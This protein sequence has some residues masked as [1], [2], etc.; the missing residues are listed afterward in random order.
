MSEQARFVVVAFDTPEQAADA[1]AAAGQVKPIDAAV[2]V[3]EPNGRLD[4]HQ[5][6]QTSPGEGAIAGGTVGLL[7]GLLF[8]SPVVGALA[9]IAAGIG[10]GFRDTGIED[11]RIRAF[12]DELAPGKAILCVLLEEEKL[13]SLRERLEPYGGETIVA[14]ATRP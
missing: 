14:E 6:K 4:V 1:L 5:S 8:A 10:W 11:D 12:G 3:R 7:A 2:L 9:G 13:P